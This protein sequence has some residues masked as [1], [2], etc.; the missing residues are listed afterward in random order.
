MLHNCARWGLNKTNQE[1]GWGN[2]IKILYA[3]ELQTA[4]ANTRW[5]NLVVAIG[6][7]IESYKS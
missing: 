1:D 3:R 4:L 2:T 5:E 7:A 6:R